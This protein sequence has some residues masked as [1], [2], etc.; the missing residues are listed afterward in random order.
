MKQRSVARRYAKALYQLA[1]ETNSLDDVLLG[2]SNIAHALKA[3]AELQHIF[4]N[5]L[6]DPADKE[7]LIK[8]ISSNKLIL[9]F[10]ALLAKRKRLNL[11][12]DIHEHLLNLSDQVRGIHRVLIKTAAA[13][14][15]TQRRLVEKDL[16]KALGGTIMGKFEVAKD[17]IGGVWIKMGDKV[18]DA[19]LKGRIEDLRHTLVHSTN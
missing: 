17:L 4:L 9:K 18:L 15:E 6:L 5:P 16:A 10:T 7:K 11:L 13:L 19:T 1:T 3:S 2:I 12:W 14:S 8:N